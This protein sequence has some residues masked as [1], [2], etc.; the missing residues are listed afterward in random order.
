MNTN[1]IQLPPEL[2][3]VGL[4]ELTQARDAAMMSITHEL[5][6]LLPA[7]ASAAASNEPPAGIPAWAEEAFTAA[8]MREGRTC[9]KTL[10]EHL[11]RRTAELVGA[12]TLSNEV[13]GKS[14]ADFLSLDL[15]EVAADGW[16]MIKVAEPSAARGNM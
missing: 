13:T 14:L 11:T 8:G 6:S 15:Y 7:M 12:T 3:R 9:W 4:L 1:S 10:H 2:A 5:Q 16:S